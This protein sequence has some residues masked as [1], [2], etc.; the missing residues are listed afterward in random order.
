MPGITMKTRIDHTVRQLG[1]FNGGLYALDLFIRWSSGGRWRLYKYRLVAQAVGRAPLCGRRGAGIEVRLLRAAVEHGRDFPRR[2]DVVAQ[3]YRQGTQCLAAYRANELLGFLWFTL[4][5]YQE[6][7][8]RARFIPVPAHAA[9]DFDVNV[10]PAH[11][12]SPAFARLWDEANQLLRARGVYWSCSRISAF[13][14]ASLS[15]HRRIG[16]VELGGALFLCCGQWQWMVAS[17]A[18]Y[19]HLSRKPTSYPQF[20]LEPPCC[21]SKKSN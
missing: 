11:Q 10:L 3:R 16:G 6:D 8:V 14:A 1:W 20:R 4:G 13:N 7:E 12:C 19:L 15:A 17:L 9:W 2:A 21:T 18:P 5:P